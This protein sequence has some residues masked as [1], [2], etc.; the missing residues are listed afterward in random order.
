MHN[1]IFFVRQVIRLRRFQQESDVFALAV[2]LWEI[3][4]GELPYKDE[5]N[6]AAVRGKV[7]I[8]FCIHRK[9]TC[10]YRHQTGLGVNG[11]FYVRF[12]YLS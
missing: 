3:V 2:V 9:T 10:L 11:L 12:C 5:N 7:F 1:L 4:V 6:Q 8:Y